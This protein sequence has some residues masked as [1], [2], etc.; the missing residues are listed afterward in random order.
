LQKVPSKRL[1]LDAVAVH[2]WI[3]MHTKHKE[4]A[5]AKK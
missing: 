2:P 5:A 4:T 3:L 1:S